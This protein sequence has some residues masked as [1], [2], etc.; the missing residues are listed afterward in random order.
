LSDAR[1]FV[2]RYLGLDLLRFLTCGSVDDGKS[3]LVGRLLADSGAVPENVLQEVIATSARLGTAAPGELDYSLLLD[4]LEQERQQGI[5]IDVAWRYFT[6]ARRKFIIA[7]TPG[8]EQYTRNM[9]TG[10]SRCDLAVILVDGSRG[11][12]EQTRRHAFIATLLGIRHLV[13]AINKMDLLGWSQAAFE[14]L[15]GQ[16]REFLARLP[17][18]DVHFVPV[19]ATQGDNVVTRSAHMP[20]FQGAPLLEHLETVHVQ[21]NRNLIDLRVSVEGAVRTPDGGRRA[22]ARVAS[23]VL[24]ENQ[25]LVVVPSGTRCR[26]A[27]IC[28][29]RR[30][31]A[32]AFAPMEVALE[33]AD[34]VDLSRGD[35]LA[36]PLN[37]PQVDH[38]LEAMLVWMDQA[39]LARGTSYLLRHLATTTPAVIDEVRY[40]IEMQSLQRQPADGLTCNQIGRVALTTTQPLG[41]D[42]YDQNRACGAFLLID[43]VTHATAAA[44]LIL[45]KQTAA[46]AMPSAQPA[47]PARTVWLGELAAPAPREPLLEALLDELRRSGKPTLRLDAIALE[48]GLL[49]D[50]TAGD[51]AAATERAR[52]TAEVCRLANAAGLTVVV[53]LPLPPGTARARFAAIVGPALL[54][55]DADAARQPTDY[56]RRLVARLAGAAAP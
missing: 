6:T 28:V 52:R 12:R 43:R 46:Q 19:A 16:C 5:T 3:T 29:D 4:G 31:V 18:H 45:A 10:A 23:G 15:R 36:P 34:E 47:A 44:G 54:T 8:H 20:W 49:S 11:V 38:R 13:V 41:H 33:F 32:E 9:A 30:T 1:A 22:L 2:D 35:L 39:P 53:T 21:S 14:A 7:D 56:A 48:S 51:D 26:V 50:L 25:E 42:P 27:S 17:V 24:R 37:V 40:R 55:A